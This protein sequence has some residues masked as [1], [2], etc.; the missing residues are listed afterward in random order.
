MGWSHTKVKNVWAGH[1]QRL[2]M[3]G[4]VTHNGLRVCGLVTLKGKSV[5]AG[6][7]QR[8]NSDVAV[9]HTKG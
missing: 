4:L 8:V 5:W 9:S 3:C 1:T 7:T 6:L 2:R